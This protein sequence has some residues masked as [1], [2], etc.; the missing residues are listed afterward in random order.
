[1]ATMRCGGGHKVVSPENT[2]KTLRAVTRRCG[3]AI[4]VPRDVGDAGER[5]D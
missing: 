5:I 2:V 1:M 3:S 4:A